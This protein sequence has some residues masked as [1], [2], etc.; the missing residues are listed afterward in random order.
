VTYTTKQ[1]TYTRESHTDIRAKTTTQV[2]QK[3][4]IHPYQLRELLNLSLPIFSAKREQTIFVILPDGTGVVTDRYSAETRVVAGTT[5]A[6]FACDA[7]TVRR[8]MRR[9]DDF[10]V[11]IGTS[12]VRY[13]V[14]MQMTREVN[15]PVIHAEPFAELMQ[16]W[17]RQITEAQ[18]YLSFARY[19]TNARLLGKAMAEAGVHRN[20]M[21]LFDRNGIRSE[22]GLLATC[23]ELH[24]D[25]GY[26][27]FYLRAGD[28]SAWCDAHSKIPS[29]RI[30]AIR[31]PN[32][33]V[34]F[35]FDEHVSYEH[36]FTF[37]M[38][39]KP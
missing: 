34:A 9:S 27:E 36:R 33:V 3:I 11:T 32:S 17:I 5:S 25:S 4:D 6:P 2:Q 16:D 35:R 38:P 8:A 18:E 22:S 12:D 26:D 39:V 24:R 20:E 15:L 21:I 14:D 28:V 7:N 37:T 19:A 1:P 29:S 10:Y 13:G 23:A 31:F 30:D